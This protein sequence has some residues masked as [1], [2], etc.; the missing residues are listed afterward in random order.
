[1]LNGN[2]NISLKKKVK[3]IY[4]LNALENLGSVDHQPPGNQ[5]DLGHKQREMLTVSTLCLQSQD[6]GSLEDAAQEEH[7]AGQHRTKVHV[8][9][10]GAEDRPG[11]HH[12]QQL[13]HRLH[14]AQGP[15]GAEPEP[16]TSPAEGGWD[17]WVQGV[18]GASPGEHDALPHGAG[19]QRSSLPCQDSH[20]GSQG[21]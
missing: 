18:Q 19:P 3:G 17:G 21:P 12:H 10:H 13:H 9:E 16:A 4:S 5:D 11:G 8:E 14:Q 7:G 6:G 2:D 15:P 1:M 20:C